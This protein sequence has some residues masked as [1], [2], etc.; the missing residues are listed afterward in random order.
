MCT[1]LSDATH[2]EHYTIAVHVEF[3]A[4]TMPSVGAAHQ[5]PSGRCNVIWLDVSLLLSNIQVQSQ[6]P[7]VEWLTFTTCA[8]N[9]LLISIIDT[10]K[11]L[12]HLCG[13]DSDKHVGLEGDIRTSSKTRVVFE[14]DGC[15]VKSWRIFQRLTESSSPSMC[16]TTVLALLL[17]EPRKKWALRRQEAAAASACSASSLPADCRISYISDASSLVSPGE[18]LLQG[19]REQNK[20]ICAD[21]RNGGSDLQ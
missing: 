20:K 5:G 6:H 18:V 17:L 2:G 16:R 4:S 11:M 19:E 14:S 21:Q 3:W 9:P 7:A 8:L 13:Y 12:G 10:P 15:T 1:Q